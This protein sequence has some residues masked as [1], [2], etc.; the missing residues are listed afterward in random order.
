[1]ASLKQA[2]QVHADRLREELTAATN[3]LSA[4]I[5]EIDDRLERQ[6]PLLPEQQP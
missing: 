6:H 2:Q 3:T 5:G 1:M 4:Y